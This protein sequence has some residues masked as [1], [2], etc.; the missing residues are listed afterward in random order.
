MSMYNYRTITRHKYQ[1]I[2]S[3]AVEYK[4]KCA[5]GVFYSTTVLTTANNITFVECADS[6]KNMVCT[7]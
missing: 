5:A 2:S 4:L 7:K 1:N 3:D 6:D